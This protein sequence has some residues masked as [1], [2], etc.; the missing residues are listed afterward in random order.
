MEIP[1]EWLSS[2]QHGH[3][4]MQLKMALAEKEYVTTHNL[5][6]FFRF[7]EAFNT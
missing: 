1:L 2:K 7:F 4:Q 5:F 6:Q 3:Y